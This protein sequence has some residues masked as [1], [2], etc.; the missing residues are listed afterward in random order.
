MS[1][2]ALIAWPM[3][4]PMVV[5]GCGEEK[6]RLGWWCSF[7][8]VLSM[9]VTADW[10]KHGESSAFPTSEGGEQSEFGG[11]RVAGKR[12]L[13]SGRLVRRRPLRSMQRLPYM[14]MPLRRTS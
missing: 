13:S 14:T 1:A 3:V 9:A 10:T 8:L 4:A 2:P 11:F 5:D 7:M 12:G 6:D